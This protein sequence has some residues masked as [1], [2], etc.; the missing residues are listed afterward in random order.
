M[1]RVQTLPANAK[2]RVAM[3]RRSPPVAEDL[4]LPQLSVT[5][6]CYD[7]P[8]RP[9]SVLHVVP[10]RAMPKPVSSYWDEVRSISTPSASNHSRSRYQL[11]L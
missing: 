7:M 10:C 8:Y 9:A 2:S 5:V 11:Y 3:H 6:S 1:M 4:S